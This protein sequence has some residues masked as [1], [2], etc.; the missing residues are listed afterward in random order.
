MAVNV[1]GAA[2]I[3]ITAHLYH[4]PTAMRAAIEDFGAR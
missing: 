2:S 4:S 1:A 3:G